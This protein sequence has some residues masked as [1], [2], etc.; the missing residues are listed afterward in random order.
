MNDYD[1]GEAV[2]RLR[3]AIEWLHGRTVVVDRD[4]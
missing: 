1:D 3:E 2:Q 4:A